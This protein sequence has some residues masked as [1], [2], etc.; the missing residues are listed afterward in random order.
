M[1]ISGKGGGVLGALPA[2]VAYPTTPAPPVCLADLESLFRD[3]IQQC[4][5]SGNLT[6]DIAKALDIF[7]EVT[8]ATLETGTPDLS[9][10][11]MSAGHPT[12]H[13]TIGNYDGYEVWKDSGAGFVFLNVSSSPNY[14]DSSALPAFGVETIWRYKIIYRY[15][16]VQIGNWSN[17]ISVAVK[18][19]V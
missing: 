17:T 9:L 16:N 18:G 15:K 3:I 14:I 8:A 19:S 11:A 5:K 2:L 7:E 12:L 6:E 4:V 13:T 10:K 1:L